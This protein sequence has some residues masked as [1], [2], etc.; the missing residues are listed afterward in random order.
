[1]YIMGQHK[2]ARLGPIRM[3]AENG[4]VHTEDERDNSF[5]SMSW[6]EALERANAISEYGMDRLRK[7]HRS[8]KGSDLWWWSL[9]RDT[10]FVEEVIDI[11]RQAREQG[12][13][14]DPSMVRARTRSLPT[15]ASI[16]VGVAND[17]TM[18]L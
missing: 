2:V 5:T 4:L 3:W 13:P 12:A 8:T 17:I 16:P 18:K 1:M 9:E 6:Q 10:K 7:G 15:S 11:I 14:D